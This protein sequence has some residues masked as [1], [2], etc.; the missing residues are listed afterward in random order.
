M[1][2][3]P[4]ANHWEFRRNRVSAD[5]IRLSDDPKLRVVTKPPTFESRNSRRAFHLLSRRPIVDR[6]CANRPATHLA[7]HAPAKLWIDN[8]S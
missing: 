2:A 8:A 6:Q 7:S 3:C 4:C 1:A 5:A